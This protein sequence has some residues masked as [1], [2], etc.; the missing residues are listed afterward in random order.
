MKAR[1]RP[2]GE[3]SVTAISDSGRNVASFSR[4]RANPFRLRKRQC[5][6]YEYRLCD[7]FDQTPIRHRQCVHVYI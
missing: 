7:R 5:G 1:Q 4:L 3:R 6:Q 2:K